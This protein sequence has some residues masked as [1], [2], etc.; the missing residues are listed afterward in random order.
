MVCRYVALCSGQ[1][2]WVFVRLATVDKNS[3]CCYWAERLSS[4]L[5]LLCATH[6]LD[7]TLPKQK[8]NSSHDISNL[9]WKVHTVAAK[10]HASAYLIG[11][12]EILQSVGH[13]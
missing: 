10:G 7:C 1:E 11:R 12:L 5:S 8:K 4:M 13:W 9:N 3:G 6:S 2:Q